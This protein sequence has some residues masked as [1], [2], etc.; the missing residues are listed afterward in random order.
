MGLYL[1][2]SLNLFKRH[3]NEAFSS[4]RIEDWKHFLRL[5]IDAEGHLTIIP[6]GLRSVPRQWVSRQAGGSGPELVPAEGYA[7][8]PILLE[9]P[10]VVGPG[11]ASGT[12][13]LPGR[14]EPVGNANGPWMNTGSTSHHLRVI[15]LWEGT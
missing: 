2:V 14:I 4:L 8:Q 1:L 13:C 9:E 15:G 5:R 12:M 11:C 10:I 3:S 7:L 6:I